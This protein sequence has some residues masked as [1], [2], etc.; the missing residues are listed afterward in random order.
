MTGPESHPSVHPLTHPLTTSPP[1]VSLAFISCS[2]FHGLAL[3]FGICFHACFFTHI[4]GSSGIQ[5]ALLNSLFSQPIQSWLSWATTALS[6]AL[7]Q[8]S[9]AGPQASMRHQHLHQE[10]AASLQGAQVAWRPVL[11]PL[12]HLRR[13]ARLQ[14]FWCRIVFIYLFIYWLIDW[15]IDWMCITACGGF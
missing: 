5:W 7:S 13:V 2:M 15:L 4:L 14:M 11:W 12:T 6:Q 3:Q 8:W 9:A 1:S 10:W